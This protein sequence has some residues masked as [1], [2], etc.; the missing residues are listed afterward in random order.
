MQQSTEVAMSDVAF[1]ADMH[2]HDKCDAWRSLNVAG[3]PDFG[4]IAGRVNR[5]TSETG[6]DFGRFGDSGQRDFQPVKP[7]MTGIPDAGGARWRWQC[8]PAEVAS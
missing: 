4:T 7:R 2:G 8:P 5:V 6:R 1:K 3:R